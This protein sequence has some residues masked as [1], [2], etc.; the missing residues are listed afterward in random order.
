MFCRLPKFSIFI[1]VKGNNLASRQPDRTGIWFSFNPMSG[2]QMA[3]KN[4][5]KFVEQSMNQTQ[6]AMEQYFGFVQ[7][8]FSS[9]PLGSPVLLEK[10]KSYTEENI[11]TSR[12]FVKQLSRAK[13]L[14]DIVRIQSQYMQ[15]Q[16]H[17]FTEQTKSLTETFTKAAAGSMKNY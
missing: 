16:F 12:E 11:A 9:L 4:V 5:D 8:A 7:K 17:A 14:Q 2:N 15:D 10:M 6:G 1:P 3:N 13:D